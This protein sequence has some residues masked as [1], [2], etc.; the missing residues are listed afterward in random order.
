VYDAWTALTTK[1][2]KRTLIS[3]LVLRI[4]SASF[5]LNIR[6][7]NGG[8]MLTLSHGANGEYLAES[9]CVHAAGDVISINDS[10]LL[11]RSTSCLKYCCL[12][13]GV[14]GPG[15]FSIALFR[16]IYLPLL[17]FAENAPP[18]CWKGKNIALFNLLILSVSLHPPFP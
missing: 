5:L 9:R 7:A 1:Q 4:I 2:Q 15:P 17:S 10:E 16:N 8:L 6:S 14:L 11:E 12:R 3:L 18:L 13:Y